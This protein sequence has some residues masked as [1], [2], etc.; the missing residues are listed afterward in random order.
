MPSPVH[1]QT[2]EPESLLKEVWQVTM[3]GTIS[4]QEFQEALQQ[5]R[6]R[7]LEDWLD[8]MENH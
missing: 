5:G 3:V 4:D 8:W 1:A 7:E 2:A 6:L